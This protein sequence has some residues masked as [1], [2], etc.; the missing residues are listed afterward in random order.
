MTFCHENEET[1]TQF[2][3]M[4]KLGRSKKQQQSA[5]LAAYE[6]LANVTKACKKAKVPRRTFYSWVNEEDFQKRFEESSKVALGVLED[7]AMRRATDGVVKPV[8]QQ[9]KKVGTVKNYS[10]TLLIVLLKARAPEK[11]KERFEGEITGKGGK[12]LF[13]DKSDDELKQLLKAT[14]EKLSS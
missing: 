5:V 13:T 4:K 6:E 8:Y 14:V 7:E 1:N 2:A 11:Y 9:G 10:D 12:D 3:H